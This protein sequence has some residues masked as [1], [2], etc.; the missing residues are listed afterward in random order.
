M[1]SR[2]PEFKS[3]YTKIS[4]ETTDNETP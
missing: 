3:F 1:F 2:Y 4:S